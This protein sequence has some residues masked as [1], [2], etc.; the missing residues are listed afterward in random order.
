MVDQ[1][2]L[3]RRQPGGLVGGLQRD[4]RSVELAVV[5]LTGAARLELLVVLLAVLLPGDLRGGAADQRLQLGQLAAPEQ[6]RRMQRLAPLGHGRHHVHPERAPQPAKLGDRR[7]EGPVVDT[8]KLNRDH[9]G[10]KRNGR[11]V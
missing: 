3:D 11:A 9:G 1:H 2:R 5:V 8:G 6:R 10:A 4:R 7:G